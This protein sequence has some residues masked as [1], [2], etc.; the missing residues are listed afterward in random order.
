MTPLTPKRVVRFFYL[1]LLL[2][3]CSML[4]IYLNGIAWSGYDTW[5][6]AAVAGDNT[7]LLV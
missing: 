5:L 1:G 3:A 4:H 6:E 2:Q 7:G